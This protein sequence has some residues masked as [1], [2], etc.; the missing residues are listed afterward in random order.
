MHYYDDNASIYS[1]T[2]VFARKDKC[3]FVSIIIHTTM[4]I[5]NTPKTAHQNVPSLQFVR[6]KSLAYTGRKKKGS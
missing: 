4:H 6:H 5:M 1:V 2:L 3:A